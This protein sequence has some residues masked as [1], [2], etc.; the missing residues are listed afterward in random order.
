[1]LRQEAMLTQAEVSRALG[2]SKGTV[3]RLWE[4]EPG[5]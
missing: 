3:W 4:R 5:V 2:Y 1:M